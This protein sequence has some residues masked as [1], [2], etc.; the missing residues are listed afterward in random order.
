M[1]IQPE[2]AHFVV[3]LRKAADTAA[4]SEGLS[5]EGCKAEFD[6]TLIT[7][8]NSRLPHYLLFVHHD[9]TLIVQR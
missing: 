7:H 1:P 4:A 6:E 9:D 2:V 5:N 8:S 3:Q